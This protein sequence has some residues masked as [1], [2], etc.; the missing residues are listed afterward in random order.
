MS[1]MTTTQRFF[2]MGGSVLDIWAVDAAAA[3]LDSLWIAREVVNWM[4]MAVIWIF[5]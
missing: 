4:Q 1:E 2:P 3:T 5:P